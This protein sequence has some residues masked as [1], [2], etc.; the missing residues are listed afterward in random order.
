M[1]KS[2]QLGKWLWLSWSVILSGLVLT[3]WVILG[4]GVD[5]QLFLAVA[6]LSF[7]GAFFTLP[8]AAVFIVAG[9]VNALEPGGLVDTIADDDW[10]YRSCVV[11]PSVA[12]RWRLCAIGL[13][14]VCAGMSVLV[15]SMQIAAFLRICFLYSL[16]FD[17]AAVVSVVVLAAALFTGGVAIGRWMLLHGRPLDAP[18]GTD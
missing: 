6:E 2:A 12:K 17:A 14:A 10:D 5:K 4:I 18:K 13:G 11:L 7:T 15:L 9:I 1:I 8:A 3:S 16:L